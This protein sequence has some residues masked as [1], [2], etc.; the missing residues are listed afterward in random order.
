M[1]RLG[2][3]IDHMPD[4]E[5]SARASIGFPNAEFSEICNQWLTI[6]QLA[7]RSEG[8][9]GIIL[10]GFMF[11]VIL[12]VCAANLAPGD[13]QADTALYLLNGPDASNEV[14][15]GMQSQAYLAE[16]WLGRLLA[17]GE[18]PRPFAGRGPRERAG[19]SFA[20]PCCPS[21]SP[22][23]GWTCPAGWRYVLPGQTGIRDQARA[24]WARISG[25]G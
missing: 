22:P 1:K 10:R 2:T 5:R 17:E 9:V 24:T 23:T 7:I 15:C 3:S 25:T 8:F 11:K 19:E 6:R 20:T 4:R 18:H 12:L 21:P 13:C 16:T 14:M